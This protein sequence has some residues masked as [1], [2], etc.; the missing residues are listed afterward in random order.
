MLVALSA[1]A[2]RKMVL[3]LLMKNRK[4]LSPAD[5]ECG[6]TQSLSVTHAHAHQA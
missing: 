2:F 4:L 5:I 1:K 3:G 6:R